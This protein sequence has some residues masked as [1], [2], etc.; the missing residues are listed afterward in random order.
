M[1]FWVTY[2]L[3]KKVLYDIALTC[4]YGIS[5]SDVSVI[6]GFFILINNTVSEELDDA[7]MPQIVPG[8]TKSSSAK[9]L[10]PFNRLNNSNVSSTSNVAKLA[11]WN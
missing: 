3:F 11:N 5:S 7:A 8:T 1:L 2:R 9:S 10:Q 6:H 4:N